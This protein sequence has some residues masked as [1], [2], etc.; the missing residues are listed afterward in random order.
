MEKFCICKLILQY[1]EL[2]NWEGRVLG[3]KKNVWFLGMLSD[4][5][6]NIYSEKCTE[7]SGL[8]KFTKN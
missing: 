8:G 1:I 2:K 5:G 6:L 7:K 3:G 4:V